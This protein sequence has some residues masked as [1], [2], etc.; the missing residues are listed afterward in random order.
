MQKNAITSIETAVLLLRRL[1]ILSVIVA[2]AALATF[3]ESLPPSVKKTVT[4]LSAGHSDRSDDAMIPPKF[5]G[6]GISDISEDIFY[7]SPQSAK[8]PHFQNEADSLHSEIIEYRSEELSHHGLNE[9]S[10]VQLHEELIQMGATACQLTYWGDKR[11][12]F[13]FSCQMPLDKHH[14]I[15]VRTFQ[16]IDADALRTMQDVLDQ[17]RQ[18][19]LSR[20]QDL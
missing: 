17:V 12:M 19:Q 3:W 4:F 5:R 16:S 11:N 8:F 14:P 7:Q 18:W 9:A 1:L 20:R 2:V 15:A 13:R 10:L 6:E